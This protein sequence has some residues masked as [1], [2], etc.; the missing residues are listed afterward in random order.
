M[1]DRRF[2]AE[3]CGVLAA[4]YPRF[5]LRKDTIEVYARCLADMPDAVLEA[6]AKDCIARS[7][8]FPTVAELREAAHGITHAGEE[9]AYEAWEQVMR[10]FRMCDKCPSFRNPRTNKALDGIGGW[11]LVG[12]SDNTFN[13][14]VNS[15]DPVVVAPQTLGAGRIE[16]G[17]LEQSNVDLSREFV[18]LITASTGF[19][20]AGRVVRTADDL[21]QELLLLVR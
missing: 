17:Q 7:R 14:G 12:L 5:T 19:S 20:A 11:R 2:V 1:A 18:G 3:M 16:A 10:S 4:A 9:T 8:F 15:G 21:L 6:A 13:V